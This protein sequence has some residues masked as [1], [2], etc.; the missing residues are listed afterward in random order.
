MYED[1]AMFWEQ[2]NKIIR[3]R[4]EDLQVGDVIIFQHESIELDADHRLLQPARH[5][6]GYYR[7]DLVGG[8]RYQQFLKCPEAVATWNGRCWHWKV[9]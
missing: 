6:Q 5:S 4:R 1:M 7:Y 2:H 8:Q 3:L 9:N